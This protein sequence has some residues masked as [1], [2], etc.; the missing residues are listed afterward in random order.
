MR[1]KLCFLLANPLC[2]H[3]ESFCIRTPEM[4]AIKKI[5]RHLYYARETKATKRRLALEV[6]ID[7]SLAVPMFPDN[8]P[9]PRLRGQAKGIEQVLRE[10]SLWRDRRGD[11]FTF[12][13]QCPVGNSRAGCDP[14]I[15][16]GCCARSLLTQQP[17]FLA[18]KGRLRRRCRHAITV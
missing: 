18:Q 13:L 12:L 7:P 4:T 14:T 16:G 6:A 2:R 5:A 15:E 1:F 10:R 3:N 8:H 11:G 9:E 17:N